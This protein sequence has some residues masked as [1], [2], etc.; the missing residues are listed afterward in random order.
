MRPEMLIT[1]AIATKPP[2]RMHQWPNPDER[3]PSGS[4]LGHEAGFLL[5]L[6]RV[7]RH[8]SSGT[9]SRQLPCRTRRQL[10]AISRLGAHA[11]A[12]WPQPEISHLCHGLSAGRKPVKKQRITM[13]HLLI[14]ELPGGNDTDIIQSALDRGDKFTFLSSQLDHYRRSA[15]GRCD[16]GVRPRAYRSRAL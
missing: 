8:R 5:V 6:G 4:G 12:P 7:V 16:A 14:I 11:A 15:R 3:L 1:T 10:R 13:A 2:A 9:N